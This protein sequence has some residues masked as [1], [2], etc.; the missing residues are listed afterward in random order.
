MGEERLKILKM[1][2]EK[3]ISAEEA[4]RLLEAIAR[5]DAAE[6]AQAAST[7][8]EFPP[9]VPPR[10]PVP[11][12]PPGAPRAPQAPRAPHSPRAP[13]MPGGFM[14][15]GFAPG[16]YTPEGFD[17]SA[18]PF[19]AGDPTDDPMEDFDPMAGFMPGGFAPGM[20][21]PGMEPRDRPDRGEKR[22]RSRNFG[23]GWDLRTSELTAALA[24]AGIARINEHMLEELRVHEVTPEYHPGDRR[25]G[26]GRSA[27]AR[28]DR[29]AHPRG[30][31][32]VR[33][34]YARRVRWD[35][36]PRDSGA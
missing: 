26:A 2:Q 35:Q 25:P 8:P 23:I 17:P 15:G 14:P 36:R 6:S 22:K 4:E 27:P 1:L 10:G 20:T 12:V 29:P 34:T 30:F 7:G 13:E 24:G 18:F 32:G 9:G 5:L 19:G 28:A 11:P 33:G 21:P 3:K 31:P 16:T